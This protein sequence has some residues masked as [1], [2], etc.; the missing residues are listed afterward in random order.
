MNQSSIKRLSLAC[1]LGLIISQNYLV[2]ATPPLTIV[3]KSSQNILPADLLKQAQDSKVS[4]LKPTDADL[5]TLYKNYPSGAELF[6]S[7]P[8]VAAKF[9]T[10]IASVQKNPQVIE[11]FRKVQMLS[12]IALYDYIMKIYLNFNLLHTG[13][14]QDQETPTADVAVYL[15]DD[16]TYATNKK[17][18]L[19]NHFVNIIQA[20]LGSYMIS[21]IPTMPQDMAVSFGKIFLANDCGIDLQQFTKP[22]TD[23]AVIAQQ[24]IYLQ[25]LQQ[26]IDFFQ[27]YTNYLGQTTKLGSNQ[28]YDLAQAYQKASTDATTSASKLNPAMFF[29]DAETLRAIQ[30]IPFVA[31]TIPD[32]SQ[33]LPWA[34]VAVNAAQKQLTVDNHPIAYFKDAAGQ[35]T[36]QQA[37]AKSL[38]ML[39]QK[40]TSLLEE[41]LLAQPAWLNNKEGSVRILKACLGD[42]SALVGAGVIDASLETIIQK[43][44]NFKP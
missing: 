41:E 24:K 33:F 2:A 8:D 6:P 40:D 28:Y 4:V 29:Y 23:P 5:R 9:N 16:A 10:M 21:Y 43:A 20:Q 15:L 13:C 39:V 27:T 42:I 44:V 36:T 1:F 11:F 35:K 37:Q 14:N 12:M 32:K 7:A 38:F 17:K 22:Q 30:F 3:T 18:L 25:F 19:I 31:S 34:P 26:Y